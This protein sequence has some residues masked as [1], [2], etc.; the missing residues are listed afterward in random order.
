[1][2]GVLPSKVCIRPLMLGGITPLRT[3]LVAAPNAVGRLPKKLTSMLRSN[4]ACGIGGV[5][6]SLQVAGWWEVAVL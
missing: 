6:G 5:H 1:M 4:T 2:R 3:E